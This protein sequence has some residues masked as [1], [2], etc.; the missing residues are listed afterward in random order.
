MIIDG[1]RGMTI[2]ATRHAIAPSVPTRMTFDGDFAIFENQPNTGAEMMDTP[3]ERMV[4]IRLTTAT[5]AARQ[6]VMNGVVNVVP[7]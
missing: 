4:P 7:I 2:S 1:V 5:G 6:A 3:K